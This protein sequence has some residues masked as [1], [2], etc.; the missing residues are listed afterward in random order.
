MACGQTRLACTEDAERIA[1]TDPTSFWSEDFIEFN[2][3]PD[4]D[5]PYSVFVY[6]VIPEASTPVCWDEDEDGNPVT[7]DFCDAQCSGLE[8]TKCVFTA[9][10]DCGGDNSGTGTCPPAPASFGSFDSPP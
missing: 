7:K 6:H 4:A 5:C 10:V 1:A 2:D 9:G 3:D 8:D